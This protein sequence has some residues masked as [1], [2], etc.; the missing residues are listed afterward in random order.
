MN[1]LLLAGV[2]VL[3]VGAGA[4]E[5]FEEVDSPPT[6]EIVVNG[7]PVTGKVEVERD[8]LINVTLKLG[9]GPVRDI[10]TKVIIKGPEEKNVRESQDHRSI[11]FVS[12][13]GTYE[14]EAWAV[15]LKQG[16]VR[17]TCS[18]MIVDSKSTV[19]SEPTGNDPRVEIA[20]DFEAIESPNKT[21]EAE[22]VAQAFTEN[23]DVITAIARS[24]IYLVGKGANASNWQ[25]FLKNRV[26]MIAKL[27]QD[28][29]I[30]TADDE[31]G[32]LQVVADILRAL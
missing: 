12:K 20:K 16:F 21:A 31:A 8:S 2:L 25:S 7:Q 19:E 29:L 15:G 18:I 14:A 9:G 11:D 4:E 26:E 17:Q 1:S 13:P 22:L 10:D 27:R 5:A 30:K 23:R 32:M 6:L 28:G 3:A 24:R